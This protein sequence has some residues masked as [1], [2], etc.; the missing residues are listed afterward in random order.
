MNK[1]RFA[2]PHGLD[3]INN[4]SCCE[5]VLIMCKEAMKWDVMR[6]IVKTVTHKAVFKIFK[7]GK[8]VCKYI[9]WVNTNKLL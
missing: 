9:H 8:V 2:N 6:K 5:D 3:H 1:T 4:Y 7:E